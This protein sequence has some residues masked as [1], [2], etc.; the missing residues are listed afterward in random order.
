VR[1]IFEYATSEKFIEW[2]GHQLGTP[3]RSELTR[4]VITTTKDSYSP[5]IRELAKETETWEEDNIT[6]KNTVHSIKPKKT[7]LKTTPFSPL[8]KLAVQDEY[9]LVRNFTGLPQNFLRKLQCKDSDGH[10]RRAALIFASSTPTMNSP[11]D[12]NELIHSLEGEEARWADNRDLSHCSWKEVKNL[13]GAISRLTKKSKVSVHDVKKAIGNKD[14]DFHKAIT[15]Q[16]NIIYSL[17]VRRQADSRGWHAEPLRDIGISYI[18]D[19]QVS[20]VWIPELL[21]SLKDLLTK[22]RDK[23]KSG[24]TSKSAMSASTGRIARCVADIP[25]LANYMHDHS[26]FRGTQ[27]ELVGFGNPETSPFYRNR[28]VILDSSPKLQALV[29]IR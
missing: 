9:H 19:V 5:H 21:S 3:T 7:V 6:K 22:A 25:W 2:N 1:G 15:Q 14:L 20:G 24:T 13:T 12:M 27:A 16:R 28:Q 29:H 17:I 23:D 4:N 11:T 8:I 26:D 10:P 18:Y